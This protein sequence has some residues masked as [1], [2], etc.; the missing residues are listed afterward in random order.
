MDTLHTDRD[1]VKGGAALTIISTKMVCSLKF[2][3]RPVLVHHTV[4]HLL[5]P[6]VMLECPRSM[7]LDAAP[8]TL[9]PEHCPIPLPRVVQVF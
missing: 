8:V 5:E 3:M 9:A 2:S 6:M 4:V 1:T 7:I